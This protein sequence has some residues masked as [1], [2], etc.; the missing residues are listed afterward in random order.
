MSQ[1]P[2]TGQFNF[3]Q[4]ASN[5]A[6]IKWEK[7][8]SPLTG[9]FNFYLILS[10]SVLGLRGF[11]SQSP[12]TGQFNFYN[13]DEYVNTRFAEEWSQSPLTGQFN[14][15]SRDSIP[16]LEGGKKVSIP[17]NGS[18]QFLSTGLSKQPDTNRVVSLNPL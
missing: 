18:I 4:K 13:G 12:L 15:Y 14:F 16:A 5:S 17:S 1:S 9:Q 7:S 10:C 11:L 6:K 3:Y 8:Q 2:L